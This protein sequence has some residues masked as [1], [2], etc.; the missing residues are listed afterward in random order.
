MILSFGCGAASLCSFAPISGFDCNFATLQC[1]RP[2]CSQ[3]ARIFAG[4]LGAV[5]QVSQPAVSQC[6]QPANAGNF[7]RCSVFSTFCRLEIGDTAGWETCATSFC[8]FA[9]LYLCVKISVHP[10]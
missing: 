1:N 10:Y 9:A 2:T 8:G 7:R 4:P 6:F 5:A 3:A